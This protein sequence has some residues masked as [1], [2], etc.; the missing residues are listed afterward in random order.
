MTQQVE[1][2]A[3][4]NGY[5]VNVI[6]MS[7]ALKTLINAIESGLIEGLSTRKDIFEDNLH[8]NPAG[9]YFAAS[10]LYAFLYKQSS[11]G[12]DGDMKT[13]S[14]RS[15]LSISKV[16]REQLHSLAWKATQNYTSH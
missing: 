2:Y 13:Q 11:E 15:Y 14:G 10:V 16:Q 1:A 8:L 5:K 9:N 6:L 7:L 12:P 3:L 4:N